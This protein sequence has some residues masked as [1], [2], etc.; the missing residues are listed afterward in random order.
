[1]ETKTGTTTRILVEKK[2]GFRYATLEK[3]LLPSFAKEILQNKMPDELV[4]RY[5]ILTALDNTFDFNRTKLAQFLRE[6]G[7]TGYSR[8][9]LY[10]LLGPP[11]FNPKAMALLNEAFSKQAEQEAFTL[12]VLRAQYKRLSALQLGGRPIKTIKK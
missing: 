4:I 6:Q 2:Y 9:H 10:K 11:L 12:L 3:T 8:Q 7:L 5:N 1:M